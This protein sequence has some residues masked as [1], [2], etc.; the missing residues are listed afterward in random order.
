LV[1]AYVPI[2]TCG[3]FSVNIYVDTVTLSGQF[4]S[5]NI[6]Q[7]Q[8]CTTLSTDNVAALVSA[9][10]VN[11]VSTV[12]T[13]AVQVSDAA[14]QETYAISNGMSALLFTIL[15]VSGSDLQA[16]QQIY[17]EAYTIYKES[18]NATQTPF[19]FVFN[20]VTITDPCAVGSLCNNL[21][22]Q[23]INE[24]KK[25]GQGLPTI[26]PGLSYAQYITEIVGSTITNQNVYNGFAAFLFAC[27][28]LFCIVYLSKNNKEFKIGELWNSFADFVKSCLKSKPDVSEKY[29]E[30]EQPILKAGTSKVAGRLHRII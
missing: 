25:V 23:A 12:V 30:D 7:K 9:T 1:A 10:S 5:T 13:T 2:P 27:F 8:L 14:L 18:V 19:N 4:S 6:N 20:K 22:Q 29:K 17:N 26:P 11:Q 21:T 16:Y 3:L 24:A 15:S 28:G